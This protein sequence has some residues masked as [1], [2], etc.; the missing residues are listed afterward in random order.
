MNSDLQLK[1]KQY[2]RKWKNFYKDNEYHFV[3]GSVGGY[4]P[5]FEHKE[6]TQLFT[7][8]I[9]EVLKSYEVL[10]TAWVIMPEHYH[11]LIWNESGI[12]IQKFMQTVLSRSSSKLLSLIKSKNSDEIYQWK[13]A[14]KSLPR[15][16]NRNYLLTVFRKRANGPVSYSLWKEQCRVI[17]MWGNKKIKTHI[18]YIHANPVRR[19][20]VD[21][22]SDYH[23][24]SYCYWYKNGK[25][26]I[27]IDVVD[28][29]N[30]NS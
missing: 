17:P 25:N 3:T 15:K 4:L 30:I 8:V 24:S 21:K 16:V 2:S 11:F 29:L 10:M 13:Y 27:P 18:D 12:R 22:P 23:L 9:K 19:G 26:I 7:D 6:F 20:I 28:G 1:T 5:L 14:R